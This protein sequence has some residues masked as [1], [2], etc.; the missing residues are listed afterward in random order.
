MHTELEKRAIGFAAAELLI[1]SDESASFYD[2]YLLF[3]EAVKKNKTPGNCDIYQPYEHMLDIEVLKL[4]DELSDNLLC[5]FKAI[6]NE[7]KGGIVQCAIDGELESD[8]NKLSMECMVEKG[9][10]NELMHF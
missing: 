7:A 4:I 8:M 1:F 6:L 9:C 3:V 5:Q 10:V 2:N